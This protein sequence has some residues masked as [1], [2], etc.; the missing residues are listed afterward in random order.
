MD[1]IALIRS[2]TNKEGNHQRATYQ[3]HTGY[4]PTGSV[5]HP[6]LAS[7]IAQQLAPPDSELPAVVSVGLTQGAGFLGVDY[8]P[9]VVRNAGRLPDNIT[10]DVPVGRFRRRLGLLSELEEEFATRGGAHPVASH[11]GTYQKASRMVLSPSTKA[12]DIRDEP[13]TLK[14]QYG[15]TPFGQGCL[16]ARRLVE[17]GVTCVEVRSNG[18]DTHEDNFRETSRLAG[19]VDPAM[20]ALI[21]DLKQRGL[22]E[23]TVVLWIGEFGRTPRITPRVGRDHYPRV[24]TTAIAGGGVRGGQVIGSSTADGT[25]IAD[26]PVTV[27]DLFTSVCTALH[28]DPTH[29]NISPLGRPM[30]IVDGG[31]VVS[32]LFG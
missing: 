3:L 25:A 13:E 29:E 27:N 14:R 21:T 10:P 31:E 17:S 19:E 9:L 22:L 7:N 6:S 8:E 24:F 12:F 1:E 4:I 32:E 18:W 11:R 5:K 30:K 20:A 26:R 15:E 2:L 23:T 28:V 16:L